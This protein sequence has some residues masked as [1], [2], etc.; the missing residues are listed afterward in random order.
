MGW[1][2]LKWVWARWGAGGRRGGLR[3]LR[4]EDILAGQLKLKCV[5]VRSPWD[6]LHRVT[7]VGWLEPIQGAGWGFPGVVFTGEALVGCWGQSRHGP[8]S[9]KA[10]CTRGAL[11]SHLE[12]TWGQAWTILECFAPLSPWLDG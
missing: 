4:A 2:E 7:L 9:P 12:L 5:Q 3:V 1:L 10:L 11:T 6:A 8:E